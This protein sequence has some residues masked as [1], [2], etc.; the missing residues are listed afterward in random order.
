MNAKDTPPPGMNLQEQAKAAGKR[1]TRQPLKRRGLR[2]KEKGKT[3]ARS[4][5]WRRKSW[6]H[7]GKGM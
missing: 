6:P 3:C 2:N 1:S 4:G 5:W 7:L